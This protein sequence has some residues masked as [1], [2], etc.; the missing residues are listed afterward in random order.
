MW[1]LI[2]NSEQARNFSVQSNK[3]LIHI[4]KKKN[5]EEAVKRIQIVSE[6]TRSAER[7]KSTTE[8][9]TQHHQKR[10]QSV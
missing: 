2:L 3:S 5:K 1:I 8:R 4:Q 7:D 6:L 9:E 10:K